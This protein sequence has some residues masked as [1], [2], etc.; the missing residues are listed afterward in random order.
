MLMFQHVW[1]ARRAR[2][3]KMVASPA[4]VDPKASWRSLAATATCLTDAQIYWHEQ[5][6]SPLDVP[7]RFWKDELCWNPWPKSQSHDPSAGVSRYKS[8]PMRDQ[9][10]P[11][12]RLYLPPLALSMRGT[13]VSRLQ[14][15]QTADV[16][17]GTFVCFR[18]SY[19]SF[20]RIWANLHISIVH[21][22]G[23]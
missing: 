13:H 4:L 14:C 3:E 7:C 11:A 12:G 9:T 16:G 8:G 23:S 6:N 2:C 22:I 19:T 10:T 15:D 20:V 17:I 1:L 18:C 21:E 5:L